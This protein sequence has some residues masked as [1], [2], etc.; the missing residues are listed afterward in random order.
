MGIQKY[1]SKTFILRMSLLL[2][3]VAA[4]ALF[5][6]YH[7]AN[8]K[9][10]EKIR[11]VPVQEETNQTFFCNQVSQI[12]L[13]TIGFELVSRSRF[14]C[15]QDK[16]LQKHFNSRTFQQIKSESV[17]TSLLVICSAHALP[18]NLVIYSSPDDTPPLG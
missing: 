9:L 12:N 13:K 8:T 15:T 18:F 6:M 16:F 1:I 7:S 11:K 14:A 17:R 4:A 5:D 10:A 3:M 2:A